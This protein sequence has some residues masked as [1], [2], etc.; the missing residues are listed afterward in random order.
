MNYVES[1]SMQLLERATNM[2]D[3]NSNTTLHYAMLAVLAQPMNGTELQVLQRLFSLA[4]V[5]SK[6]T[7]YVKRL[8]HLYLLTT[9]TTTYLLCRYFA[10]EIS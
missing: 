7:Q 2:A 5:N 10:R 8:K 1:L 6:V 9:S 3:K 4:D